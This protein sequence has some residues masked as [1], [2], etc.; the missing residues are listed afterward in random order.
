MHSRIARLIASV[1]AV[2]LVAPHGASPAPNRA[3]PPNILLILT[4]DQGW[5]EL[6][7]HGNR[8]IETPHLDRLAAEGV[9]FSR[10]YA[11]PVCTPTRAALMT[12]RHP[13]RTGAIDTFMGRDTMSDREITLAQLLRKVG[14]R[15]GLVGKWHLGRYM[16][17]HPNHRGF[18]RFFGFWQYGFINRYFDSPELFEDR[19]PVVTTG[20]V[21]DVLTDEAIRFV[22]ENRG[23]PFFLYL[24]YNAPHAPLQAPDD[25]TEKYLRKGLSFSDARIYAMIDRVDSNVGRLLA[26]LHRLGLRGDTVVLFTT[27]NG[28]TSR[29]FTAGLRGQKGTVFEGGIRVPL[30]VRWPERF[31]AGR[32]VT[33]PVQHVDLFPTLCELAGAPIPTDRTIDGRSLVPLLRA[34]GGES[35]H[36]YLYHQWCR[37]R[38]N[39]DTNWAIHEG[40]WKLV[41]GM[42]F[43]LE[44]DPSETTD[45][46]ARHPEKVAELR[47]AFLEWF[48]EVTAGQS[49]ERVPIEVGRADEDPVELDL[50]WAE[51]RGSRLQPRYLHYNRDY[52]A[53][54]SVPGDAL[55][56][57]IDVVRPG[58]YR[59]ELTYGCEPRD[60]GGRFR[61]RVGRATLEGRTEA[62]GRSGVYVPR[63]V[64]TLSLARGPAVFTMEAVTVPGRALMELHKVRLVRAEEDAPAARA[65]RVPP[66]RS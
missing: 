1:G 63:I 36:R 2:L 24:A 5:P 23:R 65:R 64:G 45:L 44:A 10:Y 50:T 40:R 16:R 49:Y 30:F 33:A 19:T 51:A 3:R 9:R 8:E 48:R 7:V 17:Y 46:A 20:Y 47:R 31:P 60:A 6:G 54:W 66:E 11:S 42:L 37:V 39:P 14:Y 13:Q 26:A 53:N 28:H 27:D 58:R 62:G 12:G 52:V 22:E 56:W 32:I 43:D 61:I 18:D 38:P 55:A 29:H 21:T 41:N 59:V 4:D 34:G 15:T 35:P 25:L 57:K